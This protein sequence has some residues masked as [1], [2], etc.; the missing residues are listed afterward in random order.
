MFKAL[1]A[2]SAE[3]DR[4]SAAE[5]QRITESKRTQAPVRPK[6]TAP[7]TRAKAAPDEYI[8]PR[9][10]NNTVSGSRVSRPQKL[11]NRGSLEPW[12]KDSIVFKQHQVDGVKW[13][14]DKKGAILG[15]EMGLGK[16]LQMLAVFGMHCWRV[17]KINPDRDCTM[18][19]VVPPSLRL[20]WA[21]E[22]EKF[23]NIQSCLVTGANVVE[24]FAQVERFR[25]LP[26]DK[27]VVLNYEQVK[28]HVQ[29]LNAFD[30]DIVVFDEAHNI[31]NPASQRYQNAKQL[32]A[33]RKFCVTGT[34]MM[35]QVVDLWTLLDIVTPGQWGTFAA[36]KSKFVKITIQ[37]D[38]KSV[39]IKNENLLRTKLSQVMLRRKIDE[40]LDLPEVNFIKR[41][42]SL[43]GLPKEM[44]NHLVQWRNLDPW[45]LIYL[46]EKEPH[47]NILEKHAMVRNLRL[48]Q[49]CAG[50]STLLP[51]SD[52]SPKLDLAI[53]D[54][55]QLIDSGEKVVVFSQ[56]RPIIEA[57]IKRLRAIDPDVPI[58]EIH[59]DVKKD[60]RQKVVKEWANTD[61]PAIIIGIIKAMGVGLNMTEARYCQ[62]I[63]KEFSPALNEQGVGRLRRIG[64]ERHGTPITV[65]EY[66]VRNSCEARVEA[67]IR[68]KNFANEAIIE[69]AAKSKGFMQKLEE[70]MEG[71]L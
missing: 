29:Q 35:N 36:F 4:R 6:R 33:P 59:G 26:G 41:N 37:G 15:D 18:V 7:P 16:T 12:I 25:A 42:V 66:F 22:I 62:F 40:V 54:V 23:T 50:T 51:D 46:E 31:K 30:I 1:K 49:I 69:G 53:E 63:D 32:N 67:I 38:H 8:A 20:N 44:Y 14:K 65:M 52:E 17:K 10:R 43:E 13:M 5:Q 39:S 47:E 64:S 56:F 61:G 28:E 3:F 24:R 19:A 71:T 9:V 70:A 21:E 11:G 2:A 68:D 60:K 48:R 34:P 55:K 57:Y 27:I 58:Y 45:G